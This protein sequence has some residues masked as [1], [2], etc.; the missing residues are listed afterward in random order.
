MS[1]IS[2]HAAFGYT[3]MPPTLHIAI[4][5]Q[6]YNHY[7]TFRLAS[8]L[9]PPLF[10]IW[11]RPCFCSCSV[12]FHANEFIY[13]FIYFAIILIR[14]LAGKPD[15]SYCQLQR[16]HLGKI[17]LQVDCSDRI[18]Q[19]ISSTFIPPSCFNL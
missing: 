16:P 8:W 9:P 7:Y 10:Q 15:N 14:S 19:P 2:C 4:L 12:I 5:Q 6:T 13:L 17:V 11:L 3:T 1:S 18:I